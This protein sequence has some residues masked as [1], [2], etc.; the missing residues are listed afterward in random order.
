MKEATAAPVAYQVP[1]VGAG[2]LPEIT[3]AIARS[4]LST[5]IRKYRIVRRPMVSGSPTD[6]GSAGY[7]R[8]GTTYGLPASGGGPYGA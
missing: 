2:H 6:G 8:N 5:I 7:F 3:A 4:T 1:H